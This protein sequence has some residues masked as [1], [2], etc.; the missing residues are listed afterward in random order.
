MNHKPSDMQ[1]FISP[2][3]FNTTSVTRSLLEYGVEGEDDV[4]LIRPA[5][6]TDNDRA[7]EAVADVEQLLQ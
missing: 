5:T 2:I 3:G 1:T 7:A 6:E 4:Q